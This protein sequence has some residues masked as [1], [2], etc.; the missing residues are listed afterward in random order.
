[1]IWWYFIMPTSI[2]AVEKTK[3]QILCCSLVNAVVVHE[4]EELNAV[5][6][7]TVGRFFLGTT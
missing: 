1:M 3:E 7:Q 5:Q 6:M 2:H 4:A